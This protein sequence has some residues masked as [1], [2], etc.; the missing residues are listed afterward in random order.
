[1]HFDAEFGQ[2]WIIQVDG[3]CERRF[4]LFD[5]E[6][7]KCNSFLL[8]P[9]SF[10]IILLQGLIKGANFDEPIE[11]TAVNDVVVDDNQKKPW[12]TMSPQ[13]VANWID[14]RCRVAFPLAFIIFNLFFWLYALGL[15]NN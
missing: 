6:Y 13:D 11:S 2:K 3:T 9:Q 15:T 5:D 4:Y 14:T 1:M 12:T 10:V 7:G 8:S